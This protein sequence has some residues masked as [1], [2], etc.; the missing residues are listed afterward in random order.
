MTLAAG[1]LAKLQECDSRLVVVF[2]EVAKYYDLA[3]LEGYRS[4]ARQLQLYR[5][6]KSRVQFGKHNMVPSQ[7][8][9]IA[10]KPIDWGES[11]DRTTREKALKRFYF[12]AGFVFGLANS[13]QIKLRWGG[14]W[15]SDLDFT[16]QTFDDLC[17]FEVLNV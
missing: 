7:A 6:G 4:Q 14:D 17:H 16:D 3:V 12:L 13:M 11:G 9:D 10:L 5:E 2:S 1:D 15:D 8:V